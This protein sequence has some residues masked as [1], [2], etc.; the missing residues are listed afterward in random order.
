MISYTIMKKQDEKTINSSMREAPA[1]GKK[2]RR[3]GLEK[4]GEMS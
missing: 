1:R 3:R 4:P 2:P